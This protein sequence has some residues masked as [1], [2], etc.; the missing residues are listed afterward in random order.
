M[1]ES[2]LSTARPPAFGIAALLIF[3][4]LLHAQALFH[5]FFLDDYVYLEKAHNFGWQKLVEILTTPALDQ[6]ASSVW[7]P[8]MAC[9]LS[10]HGP[11]DLRSRLFHLV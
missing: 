10:P 4:V 1:Q 8:S 6:S 5:P 7:W 2:H 11:V 9:C 3:T